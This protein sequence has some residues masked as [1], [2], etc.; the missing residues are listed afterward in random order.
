MMLFETLKQNNGSLKMFRLKTDES[1]VEIQ[2]L[3]KDVKDS[4]PKVDS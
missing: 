3:L 2:K 4:N 1:T